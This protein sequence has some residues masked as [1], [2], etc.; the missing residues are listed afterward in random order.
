MG[1]TPIH[2]FMSCGSPYCSSGAGG[3][4]LGLIWSAG[5]SVH[6]SN[7]W[8]HWKTT[9]HFATVFMHAPREGLSVDA[10][11]LIPSLT[12]HTLGWKEQCSLQI[13]EFDTS[14]SRFASRPA[15]SPLCW[16]RCVDNF[17][18]AVPRFRKINTHKINTLTLNSHRLKHPPGPILGWVPAAML[19]SAFVRAT[20][21]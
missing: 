2:F 4:P 13:F 10:V 21:H 3:S 14:T 5:L 1:P 15:C 18:V 16:A 19:D 9:W 6:K 8:V 20:L 12:L 17:D 7:T 11:S